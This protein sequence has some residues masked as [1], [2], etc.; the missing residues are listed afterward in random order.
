MEKRQWS[1]GVI[2]MCCSAPGPVISASVNVCPASMRTDGE[3]FHPLPRSRDALAP[4]PLTA[5]PPPP[6]APVKFS[7]LIDRDL[8][9][10][11]RLKSE[12]PETSPLNGRAAEFV[13]AVA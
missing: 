10:D 8:A 3:T 11:S 5:C 1:V 12:R 9:R 2:Q 13:W 7:G 4:V 6:F